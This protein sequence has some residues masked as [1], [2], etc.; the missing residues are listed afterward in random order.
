MVTFEPLTEFTY[1]NSLERGNH[2]ILEMLLERNCLA[3]TILTSKQRLWDF[4]LDGGR[5]AENWITG[6]IGSLLIVF[7]NDHLQL[8]LGRSALNK[9]RPEITACTQ[10]GRSPTRWI[11]LSTF[12]RVYKATYLMPVALSF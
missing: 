4:T 6:R 8:Q 3:S 7:S 9:T 2:G 12:K 1:W 5:G 10:F 11:L